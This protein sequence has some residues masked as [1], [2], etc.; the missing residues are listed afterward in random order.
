MYNPPTVGMPFGDDVLHQRQYATPCAAPTDNLLNR[1]LQP[2]P[3]A[4]Q[5]E[6]PVE[7][8]QEEQPPCER[9]GTMEEHPDTQAIASPTALLDPLLAAFSTVPFTISFKGRLVHDPSSQQQPWQLEFSGQVSTN[10]APTQ[11][12]APRSARKRP[13]AAAVSTDS[14][15]LPSRTDDEEDDDDEEYD[16]ALE[17]DD[18]GGGGASRGRRIS[19]GRTNMFRARYVMNDDCTEVRYP[20]TWAAGTKSKMWAAQTKRSYDGVRQ[21]YSCKSCPTQ[22][23][24]CLE[25][26]VLIGEL[27]LKIVQRDYEIIVRGCGCC[28]HNHGGGCVRTPSLLST[29]PTAARQCNYSRWAAGYGGC[30]YVSQ[31]RCRS[32]WAQACALLRIP[33]ATIQRV[34]RGMSVVQC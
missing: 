3:S 10:P 31:E 25:L 18:S 33:A 5:P 34:T 6:P 22:L 13:R 19:A 26:Q 9:T 29:T 27:P 11:Q 28:V 21:N 4:Q 30:H 20:C 14:Y 15:E 16:D 1:L 2:Q 8:P 32:Q 12:R 24:A 7:Q 23:Q 17:D